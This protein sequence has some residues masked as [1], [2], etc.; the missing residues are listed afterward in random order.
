VIVLSFYSDMY[1]MA[2]NCPTCGAI[3]AVTITH[4]GPRRE[5]CGL[6]SWGE[7]APLVSAET[8]AVRIKAHV[9]F[10]RLWKSGQMSRS[11]AYK[12]LA[13]AMGLH[14][15]DCH[16]KLMELP[17]LQKVIEFSENYNVG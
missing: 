4:Y 15:R 13:K 5:C 17:M 6:W 11:K 2:S 1:L 10:D 16:M 9:A 14:K 12:E 3:P 7:D 8:H